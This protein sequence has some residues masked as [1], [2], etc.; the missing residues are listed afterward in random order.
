MRQQPTAAMLAPV[1]LI[2]RFI[3]GGDDGCLRAFAARDVVILENFAPH[4][5][6]GASAVT[7]WAKQ[8]RKHTKALSGLKHAFGAAQDV[9]VAAQHAYFALPTQWI[10]VANG[11]LFHEDG[12]WAFLLVK[13]RG[14]WR[15]RSYSWAV[16]QFSFD[17]ELRAGRPAVLR[18]KVL[19]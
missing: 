13:Q 3:A 6:T 11:R 12:G 18:A 4:L 2:A 16:T 1:E 8:M 14:A 10:G 19:D 5:F 15:V 9:R 7:Q 17:Q